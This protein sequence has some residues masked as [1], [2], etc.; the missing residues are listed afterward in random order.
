VR[1]VR[2]PS[3]DVFWLFLLSTDSAMTKIDMCDV[4]G[5][6]NLDEKPLEMAYW[7]QI[8]HGSHSPCLPSKGRHVT[9]SRDVA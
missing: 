5:A 4:D 8:V 1:S 7:Y 6:Y 3:S 9:W 2:H